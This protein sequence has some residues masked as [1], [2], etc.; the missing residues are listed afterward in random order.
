[1]TGQQKGG[2]EGNVPSQ[3]QFGTAERNPV[4]QNVPS[5]N[6]QS[7]NTDGQQ[8]AAQSGQ[9]NGYNPQR[10]K[11]QSGGAKHMGNH[12]SRDGQSSAGSHSSVNEQRPNEDRKHKKI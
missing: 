9:P 6:S 7:G 12:H 1:M 2:S 5:H 10:Q 3:S 11:F 8:N 4:G